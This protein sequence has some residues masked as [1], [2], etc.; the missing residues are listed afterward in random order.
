MFTSEYITLNTGGNV[1]LDS[2]IGKS[3]I[4]Y[5]KFQIK[6]V[7]DLI[8]IESSGWN[9]VGKIRNKQSDHTREYF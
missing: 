1:F 6:F 3:K 5:S 8:N 9:L 4:F 7:Q 2:Y